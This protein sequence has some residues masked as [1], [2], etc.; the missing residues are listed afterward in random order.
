MYRKSDQHIISPDAVRSIFKEY[1]SFEYLLEKTIPKMNNG[2]KS[3]GRKR[4]RDIVN[5]L[6]WVD[7][8]RVYCFFLEEDN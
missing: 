2:T 5:T 4:G 3:I 1:K 7:P 8:N 6:P